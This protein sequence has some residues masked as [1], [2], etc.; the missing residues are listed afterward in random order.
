MKK[1][2]IQFRHFI[3][4]NYKDSKRENLIQPKNISHL[5]GEFVWIK[6]LID[7]NEEKYLAWI[8]NFPNSIK[9]CAIFV[10]YLDDPLEE[11]LVQINSQLRLEEFEIL[12]NF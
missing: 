1:I 8:M 2:L 11:K 3:P 5:F 9:L 10:N 6:Y 7:E 4:K 12:K